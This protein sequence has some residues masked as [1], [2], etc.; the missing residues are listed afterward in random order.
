MATKVVCRT[1]CPVNGSTATGGV[2]GGGWVKVTPRTEVGAAAQVAALFA[3]NV[4]VVD[5]PAENVNPVKA[6]AV[7]VV[8]DP[9][10]TVYLPA[11]TPVLPFR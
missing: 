10:A 3:V 8:V 5:A 7:I 9:Y 1:G 6:A 2:L 4:Q 11:A